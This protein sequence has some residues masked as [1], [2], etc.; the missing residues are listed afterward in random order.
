MENY[1]YVM[2]VC[3]PKNELEGDDSIENAARVVQSQIAHGGGNVS[4]RPLMRVDL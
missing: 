2:V 1:A 3:V 4:V